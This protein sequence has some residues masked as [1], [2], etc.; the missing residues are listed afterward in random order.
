MLG[1]LLSGAH[2]LLRRGLFGAHTGLGDG[3]GHGIGFG[4]G[5]GVAAFVDVDDC[6]GIAVGVVRQR[7]S[8]TTTRS[9]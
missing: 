8:R 7:P 3:F 2:D 5:D 1:R 4:D 6:M 9:G